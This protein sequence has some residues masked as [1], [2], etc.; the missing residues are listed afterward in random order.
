MEFFKGVSLPLAA[1]LNP[2][3]MSTAPWAP[4]AF[5]T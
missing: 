2:V 5:S 4:P 1:T 3:I